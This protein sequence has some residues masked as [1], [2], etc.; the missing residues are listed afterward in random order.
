MIVTNRQVGS[1][2]VARQFVFLKLN[3]DRN[4]ERIVDFGKGSKLY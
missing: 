3:D 1:A 2:V 4:F